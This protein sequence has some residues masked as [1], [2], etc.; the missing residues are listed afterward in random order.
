MHCATDD[1][2][3]HQAQTSKKDLG[4]APRMQAELLQDQRCVCKE[5]TVNIGQ[6]KWFIIPVLFWVAGNTYALQTPIAI[7]NHCISE[8]TIR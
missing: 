1:V 5:L 3:A 8:A 6:A 2:Y 4:K 7:P